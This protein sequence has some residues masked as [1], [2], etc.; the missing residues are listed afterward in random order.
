MNNNV[1]KK[2]A[3]ITAQ[4]LR[5][6]KKPRRVFSPQQKNNLNRFLRRR[7]RRRKHFSRSEVSNCTPLAYNRGMKRS[8]SLFCR[9]RLSLLR[10]AESLRCNQ[11]RLFALL[12]GT[13][14]LSP[15]QNR[16]EAGLIRKRR[17]KGYEVC[18]DEM[19][20]AGKRS[21]HLSVC[22]GRRRWG[23]RHSLPGPFPSARRGGC[24]PLCT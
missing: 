20:A 1:Y 24:G 6:S 5:L 21:R 7:V 13:L 15:H 9:R 17:N 16:G 10:Q 4:A 22:N 14:T 23:R 11:R 3:L 12:A 8:A 2:P 18:C 19:G